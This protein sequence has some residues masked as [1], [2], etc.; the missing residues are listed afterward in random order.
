[1]GQSSVCRSQNKPGKISKPGSQYDRAVIGLA[2]ATHPGS[3]SA[4]SESSTSGC[5][6]LRMSVDS[7]ERCAASHLRYE[8]VIAAGEDHVRFCFWTNLTQVN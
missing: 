3:I 8:A 2:L 1:M 6:P 7:Q 4:T 5:S